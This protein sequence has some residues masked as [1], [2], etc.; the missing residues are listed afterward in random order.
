[1][2]GAC[3]AH[4]VPPYA[5]SLSV[6]LWRDS[7]NNGQPPYVQ[8]F[9]NGY[10]KGPANMP[11]CGANGATQCPLDTFLQHLDQYILPDWDATCDYH[12]GGGGS[13]ND[14]LSTLEIVLISL[15]SLM[16][17]VAIV[18]TILFL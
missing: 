12:Q 9:Y 10:G 2:A 14:S 3:S 16:T 5:S 13:S 4:V 15:T 1:M 6:E 11:W 8:V 7:S 17:L 18:L